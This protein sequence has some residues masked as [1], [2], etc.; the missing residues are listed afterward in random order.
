MRK[1]VSI[2]LLLLWSFL[3][4]AAQNNPYD[5]NDE[6]YKYFREA[7]IL[8]GKEGF[9][10]VN[11]ALLHSAISHDDTKAQT[12]YYVE[13]L[14]HACRI[15]PNQT[16]STPQQDADILKKQEELKEVADKFGYPQYF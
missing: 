14:K 1:I 9:E 2:A 13:R 4:L 5:L 15:I 11:S 7:E 6:C 10:E 12:L 8:A 3:N 16:L